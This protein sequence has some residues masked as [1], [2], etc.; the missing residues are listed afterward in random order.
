MLE[1]FPTRARAR[2]QCTRPRS[3]ASRRASATAARSSARFPPGQRSRSPAT[4]TLMPRAVTGSPT[5]IFAGAAWRPSSLSPSAASL[6]CT[7][8]LDVARAGSPPPASVW[9]GSIQIEATSSGGVTS[10]SSSAAKSAPRRPVANPHVA[11]AVSARSTRT[12]PVAA[13]AVCRRPPAWPGPMPPRASISVRSEVAALDRAEAVGRFGVGDVRHSARWTF[14]LCCV[15]A[16]RIY[17]GCRPCQFLYARQGHHPFRRR[18]AGVDRVQSAV[19]GVRRDAGLGV[20]LHLCP[21]PAACRHYTLS[22]LHD[23][24]PRLQPAGDEG[25]VAHGGRHPS[26]RHVRVDG[27]CRCRRL[28]H[29]AR[30]V[31]GED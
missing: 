9:M 17:N 15:V 6:A 1:S 11:P 10:S 3:A 29:E 23:D 8:A 14:A 2:F 4:P 5:T 13:A 25:E 27:L 12:P 22:V 21:P 20:V 7:H 24:I 30:V 26:L 31:E 18:H 16:A 19:A 28:V